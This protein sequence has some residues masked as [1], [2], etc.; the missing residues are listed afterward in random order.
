MSKKK[1]GAKKV[2]ICLESPTNKHRY[3][4]SLYTGKNAPKTLK[5]YN[6]ITRKREIY[7]LVKA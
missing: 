4:L 3:H 7:N 2:V 6:P 5:K 1:K